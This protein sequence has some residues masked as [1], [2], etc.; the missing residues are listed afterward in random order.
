[1]K[2]LCKY[3]SIRQ[4]RKACLNGVTVYAIPHKLNP[5][6]MDGLFLYTINVEFL[7]DNR[8]DVTPE[9]CFDSVISELTYYNCTP[10]TGLYLSFYYEREV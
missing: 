10:E 1:M 2:E 6:Y 9:K 8:W 3:R 5:Y 4:A 7:I